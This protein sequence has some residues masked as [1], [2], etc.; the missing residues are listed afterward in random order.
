MSEINREDARRRAR[1]SV[2]DVER[3]SERQITETTIA[4]T[5]EA[6]VDD[7]KRADGTRKRGSHSKGREDEPRSPAAVLSSG[8]VRA[9]VEVIREAVAM[10]ASL[11][12]EQSYSVDWNHYADVRV[13]PLFKV[14]ALAL[15]L[16][17]DTKMRNAVLQHS[18]DLAQRYEQVRS[19]LR[20]KLAKEKREGLVTCAEIPSNGNNTRIDVLSALRVLREKRGDLCPQF[21]DLE[22]TLERAPDQ[23]DFLNRPTRKEADAKNES[24][25]STSE[26]RMLNKQY[27]LLLGIAIVHYDLDLGR[28]SNIARVARELAAD[29]ERN[30]LHH[31][32]FGFDGI[33]SALEAAYDEK[34]DEV[35]GS[36]AGKKLPTLKVKR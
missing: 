12:P 30:G 4:S 11:I 23:F 2:F 19:Y 33:K 27:A 18:P 7:A 29:F 28:K 8:E 34:K 1:N 14:A 5:A 9:H 35:A 10:L 16:P 24:K 15:G 31:D 20:S 21:L 3:S 6:S 13:L 36:P 32:G 26:Q 17:T 22:P 25:L